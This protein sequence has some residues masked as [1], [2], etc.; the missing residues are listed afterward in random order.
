MSRVGLNVS[1]SCFRFFGGCRIHLSSD[2]VELK[3]SLLSLIVF[4]GDKKQKINK[5]VGFA[6]K[7][8]INTEIISADFKR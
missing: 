7:L 5:K 3:I 6:S 4:I 1:Q 8:R 2:I